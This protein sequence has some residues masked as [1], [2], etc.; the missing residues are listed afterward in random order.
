V[1]AAAHCQIIKILY[2]VRI[3]IFTGPEIS[4]YSAAINSCP[5]SNEDANQT[6]I[7]FHL[8]QGLTMEDING[9]LLVNFIE[10]R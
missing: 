10:F 8:E 2:A 5:L 1:H 9:Y 3:S 7:F 4:S 6:G